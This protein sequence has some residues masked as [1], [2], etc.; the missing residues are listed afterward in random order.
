MKHWRL[1]LSLVLNYIV[2]AMLLNSVGTVILQVQNNFG[3]TKGAASVL[4]AFKDLPIAITSFLIA[5][6]VVRI[7]YKNT[8][9]MGLGL[10]SVT[11]MIM[12][13]LPFFWMTK[14]LFLSIGVGF[15]CIKVSV[16][17]TLGLVSENEK[18][19]VSFMSFLESFF[20][21]GVLGGYFL[22]SAFVDQNDPAS[23]SWMRVY[24]LLGGCAIFAFILLLTTKVDESAVHKTPSEGLVQD[25][26]K[27]LKLIILPLVIVFIISIFFYVLV[28][29]SIMSWLPTF[30][31]QILHLP[32]K[33][34][35][36]MA[37]ILAGST[38]V[39]RFLGGFILKKVKWYWVVRISLVAA[40]AM[41]LIGLP[42]ALHADASKA[43]GW[44]DAP[45]AVFIFPIIGLF[46]APIYPT[47]NSVMLSRLPLVQHGPMSGLIVVFS[48]LGGT[49]GSII[50]GNVFQH[51]GGN[52][53]FYLSLIP[54]TLIMIALLFFKGMTDKQP[55]FTTSD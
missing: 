49:T 19:H 39:G 40:A 41:V 30:N 33:L 25:F 52:N 29:Q 53:A 31:N 47:I 46:L 9:L 8:M 42:L 54:I 1:K 43:T 35:I 13:N 2:F 6:F 7:G 5:S 51:F 11:C 44:F 55:A 50:T 32:S 3:V 14:L 12:P 23:T 48:A 10:V 26:S 37:S 15:A 17:A 45:A 16:F 4:E 27:M 28:E 18:E 24:Y 22:F 21:V 38:A 20:M 34:S 36:E